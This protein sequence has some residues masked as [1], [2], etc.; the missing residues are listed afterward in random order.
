MPCPQIEK[1]IFQSAKSKLLPL[2]IFNRLPLAP[3]LNLTEEVYG[4]RVI[5]TKIALASLLDP[6]K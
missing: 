3:T 5:Q 1:C 2:N 6:I 4:M